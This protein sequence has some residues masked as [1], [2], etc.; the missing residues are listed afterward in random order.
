MRI[1]AKNILPEGR[2][3]KKLL[4]AVD[5]SQ[6]SIHALKYA[7]ILANRIKADVTMLWV[8]DQIGELNLY[9]G[10]RVNYRKEDRESFEEL[11]TD[12]KGQL[13]EGKLDYK[14][15]RGKVYKEVAFVADQ[16]NADLVIVGSHGVS[17]YEQYWIGSN[18][19]RIVTHSACPVITIRSD[20]SLEKNM[21]TIVFPV[22]NTTSTAQK[23]LAVKKFAKAASMKVLILQLYKTNL[24]SIRRKVDE[25]THK[26]EACFKDSGVDYEIHCL[27]TYN[28]SSSILSFARKKGADIIA[29][30]TEQETTAAS[31]M[32]GTLAQQLVNHADCPVFNVQSKS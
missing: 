3:M 13:T 8:D 4:V 28:P 25:Y 15:R 21:D 1:L 26:A 29:I 5:F 27:E 7:I 11:L 12:H 18:A 9:K 24:K 30:M 2:E 14:L 23:A 31:V 19:Y 10:S 20:Y 16:I 6:G 22:D 32:M 17:G